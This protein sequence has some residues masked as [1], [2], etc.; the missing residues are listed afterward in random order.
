VPPS[1]LRISRDSRR[2][3]FEQFCSGLDLSRHNLIRC[4]RVFFLELATAQPPD[5]KEPDGA[6]D[7]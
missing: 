2:Q 3:K 7:K 4:F 5:N 1:E 6:A